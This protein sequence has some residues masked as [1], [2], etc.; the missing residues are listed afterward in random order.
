MS[1]TSY[2]TAKKGVCRSPMESGA[3]GLFNKLQTQKR[4]IRL[5]MMSYTVRRKNDALNTAL[6]IST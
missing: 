2:K 3:V 4:D 1:K 6:A 5:K